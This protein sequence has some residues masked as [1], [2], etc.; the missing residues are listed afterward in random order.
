MA[1]ANCA[2][3]GYRHAPA[4]VATLGSDG[5][6]AAPQRVRASQRNDLIALALTLLHVR[7]GT[8]PFANLRHPDAASL[9]RLRRT[10]VCSYVLHT[11]L[12]RASLGA[13]VTL[14]LEA[15]APHLACACFVKGR[16]HLLNEKPSLCCYRAHVR[17]QC[18]MGTY[19]VAARCAGQA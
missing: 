6:P 8:S 3:C 16:S 17:L 9:Q 4:L 12:H 13:G 7:L 11:A 19:S 5:V 15:R 10:G 18:L 1:H 2:V 14:L